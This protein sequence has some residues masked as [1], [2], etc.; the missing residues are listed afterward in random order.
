LSRFHED[1][2]NYRAW[3]NE[4]LAAAGMLAD[5][6]PRDVFRAIT[7][8]I[9]ATGF[10]ESDWTRLAD[11]I[12]ERDGSIIE[13]HP[14]LL[15]SL[16][17]G[18]DDYEGTV[19][20]VIEAVMSGALEHVDIIAHAIGLKEWLPDGDP[21]RNAKLYGGV[22]VIPSEKLQDQRLAPDGV[23]AAVARLSRLT[24]EHP[25]EVIGSAKNLVESAAKCV[26]MKR[27]PHAAVPKN[28]PGLVKAAFVALD[29][30]PAHPLGPE[31]IHAPI[32]Q[33]LQGLISSAS[34]LA[35]LRNEAGDG[36]GSTEVASPDEI[37][38][39]AAVIR[40]TAVMIT[41]ILLHRLDR[42]TR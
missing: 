19:R 35:E 10:D 14:R 33:M 11:D 38:E 29:L 26:L 9:V 20:H 6:E 7:S 24:L 27:T 13:S 25:D 32:R 36:H 23:R 8:C 3:S 16:R 41:N 37:R 4:N 12:G 2:E 42:V 31:L 18:D 30:D 15:R 34:A 22:G 5:R 39:A 1:D 40:D 21:I 28:F 17:W